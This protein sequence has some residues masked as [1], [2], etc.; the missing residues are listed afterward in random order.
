MRVVRWDSAASVV[1]ASKQC[2]ASRRGTVST[3]SYTQRWSYPRDSMRP[4]SSTER[5]HASVADQPVYSSFQPCGT[6]APWAMSP[7]TP[8]SPPGRRRRR[9]VSHVLPVLDLEHH[10]EQEPGVEGVDLHDLPVVD[11]RSD[12]VHPLVAILERRGPLP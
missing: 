7:I 6:K 4:A 1:K 5:A 9:R 3:W 12:E 10:R 2:V 8:A 11:R